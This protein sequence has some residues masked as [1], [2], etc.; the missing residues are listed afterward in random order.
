MIKEQYKGTTIHL[1][2]RKIVVD[3]LTKKDIPMLKK[4]NLEY[5]LEEKSKKAKPFKGVEEDGEE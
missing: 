2:G 3:E 1:K 5:L 4:L